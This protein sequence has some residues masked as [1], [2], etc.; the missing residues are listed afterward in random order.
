MK[1]SMPDCCGHRG[2]HKEDTVDEVHDILEGALH[3]IHSLSLASG[4]F[5]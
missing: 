5:S 1:T 3:T 2:Q 4:M